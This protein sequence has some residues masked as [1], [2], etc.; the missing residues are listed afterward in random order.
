MAA[1]FMRRLS[2]G[3]VAVFSGGSAPAERLNPTVVAAMAEKGIDISDQT[4]ERWTDEGI[5]SADVVV[6]MGCG[7]TCPVI[8]GKRYIDWDLEDPSGQPI[9]KVRQIRDQVEDRVR[10]LLAELSQ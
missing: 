4:P 8:P 10:G 7:D 6:T 9:E 2:E 1:G 3:R 5:R